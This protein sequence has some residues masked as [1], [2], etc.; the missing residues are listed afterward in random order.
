MPRNIETEDQTTETLVG[1]LIGKIVVVA[2][3][4]WFVW[5]YWRTLLGAMGLI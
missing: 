4:L 3:I 2:L 5:G 1:G